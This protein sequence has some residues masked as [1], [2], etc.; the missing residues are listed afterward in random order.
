MITKQN[1]Y[2]YL[3]NR[4][5]LYKLNS[6]RIISFKSN[7]S[8]IDVVYEYIENEK[9]IIHIYYVQKD[10]YYKWC[11]SNRKNKIKAIE[12]I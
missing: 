9:T 1:V 2:N 3:R 5:F 4:V 10:L 7:K 8:F 11:I 12:K 6:F